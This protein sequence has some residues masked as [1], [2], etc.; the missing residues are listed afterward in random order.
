MIAGLAYRRTLGALAWVR[1]HQLTV[2]RIGGLMLVAVGVLLVTGWWDQ[3]VSWLQVQLVS[4][5]EVPV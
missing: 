3:I 1:K 2:M 4:D 5:F